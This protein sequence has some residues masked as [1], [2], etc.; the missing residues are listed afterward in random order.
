V[1]SRSMYSDLLARTLAESERTQPD[2]SAEQALAE[3]LRCRRGAAAA[4]WRAPGRS[5]VDS[6]LAD[7]VAYDTALIRYAGSL[8]LECDVQG[9][10]WP[11]DERSRIERQLESRGSPS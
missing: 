2:P 3:Y 8:G 5:W 9:F 7:E 10:G 6:A 11:H 4:G 1:P